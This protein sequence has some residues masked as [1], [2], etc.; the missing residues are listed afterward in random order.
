MFRKGRIQPR[1][2]QKIRQLKYKN[3]S[4][5]QKYNELTQKVFEKSTRLNELCENPV[6]PCKIDGLKTKST[7]S[8]VCF[9][10]SQN[11]YRIFF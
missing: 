5:I 1:M 3:A 4:L 9:I 10:F 8:V 7:Q 2:R 11:L 6:L